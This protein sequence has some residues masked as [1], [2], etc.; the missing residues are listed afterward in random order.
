MKLP[1]AEHAHVD[2]DKLRG[3]CLSIGHPRGRHKA[4]VFRA[5]LD[6]TDEDAG[7]L[8]DVLLAGAREHEATML[9]ADRFGQGY[10]VL[11]PA[12]RG[13]RQ[14]NIRSF[15]IVRAGETFPRLTTCFV[16]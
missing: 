11:I 8:R 3:Y 10:E 4:R 5:A 13:D 12:H 2:L 1:N 14:A 9:E 6:V 16:A 15:W 7:W